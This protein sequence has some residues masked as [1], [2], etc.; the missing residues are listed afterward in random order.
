[1]NEELVGRLRAKH[2]LVEARIRN[3]V[4]EAWTVADCRLLDAAITALSSPPPKGEAVALGADRALEVVED[5]DAEMWPLTQALFKAACFYA[6]NVGEGTLEP[7]RAE[8]WK[9]VI[10]AESA[11]LLQYSN[12]KVA[13]A[14][15]PTPSVP[16]VSV[17]RWT[18][19]FCGH[20]VAQQTQATCEECGV[21]GPFVQSPES[22]DATDRLR[23]LAKEKMTQRE[24]TNQTPCVCGHMYGAHTED[25]PHVCESPHCLCAHFRADS[26][27][28]TAPQERT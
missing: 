13:L 4:T 14:Q 3:S 21:F 28:A 17:T 20:T 18:C 10:D 2:A 22:D 23:E 1:M 12:A 11:I 26:D 16:Q 25:H 7:I 27:D 5:A 6:R 19:R 15:Y 9:K 8:W 24:R